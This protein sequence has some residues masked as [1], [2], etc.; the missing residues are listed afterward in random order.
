MCIFTGVVDVSKT[1]IFVAKVGAN[2]QLTVYSNTVALPAGA[3]SS[4]TAGG[5]WGDGTPQHGQGRRQQAQPQTQLKPQP[6]SMV[7]P[8]PLHGGR[9]D[10]IRMIDM[11]SDPDFFKRLDEAVTQPTLSM[12]SSRNRSANA[13]SLEVHQCGPYRYSVVPD[14]DAFERLREDVF[15]TSA[16]LS[17]VLRQRYAAVA[18][19]ASNA[20]TYAFLVCIID[21]SSAFSPI[22]YVH[23]LAGNTLFVPTLHEHGHGIGA[24]ADDWDHR[25]YSIDAAFDTALLDGRKVDCVSL[26]RAHAAPVLSKECPFSRGLDWSRL[27]CRRIKG[28]QPNGDLGIPSA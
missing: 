11:T 25:V 19:N 21:A 12:N 27:G 8:I 15:G 14:V 5:V 2:E 26:T 24:F 18:S 20:S 23:P 17:D 3:A 10:S 22:A 13:Y 4:E 6:T 16:R 7:L 1:N 28:R 9:A